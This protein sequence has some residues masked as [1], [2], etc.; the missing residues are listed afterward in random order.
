MN[1]RLIDGEWSKEAQEK[2]GK[3]PSAIQEPKHD[4]HAIKIADCSGEEDVEIRVMSE[5]DEAEVM[6]KNFVDL[7]QKGFTPGKAAKALGTS[8]GAIKEN[9]DVRAV[10]RKLMT[11]AY[12][13]PE[14]RKA[15]VRAGLMHLALDNVFSPDPT[16][17]KIALDALKAAGADVEVGVTGAMQQIGVGVNVDLSPL[18]DVFKS[19]EL[20]NNDLSK[21]VDVRVATEGPGPEL[22]G[23]GEEEA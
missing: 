18:A 20:N 2:P 7:V 16:E 19:L 22:P 15:L 11:Q 4:P 9:Q 8:L 1:T 21:I 12:F 13:P 6:A 14:A 23:E 10:A 5:G 3:R 17:K